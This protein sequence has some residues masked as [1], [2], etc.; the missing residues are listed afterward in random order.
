MTR[1]LL[2]KEDVL[3]NVTARDWQ[4]AVMKV[5]EVMEKQ[6]LIENRYIDSMVKVVREL[7]PYIVLAPGIAFPHAR[8]EDGALATGIGLIT[9][10]QPVP[11][12]NVDNDPVK[13]VIGLAAT[14]NT[15]HLGL[16]KQLCEF[17]EDDA[18]IDT[19]KNATDGAKVAELINQY[20][21]EEI[22]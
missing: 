13:I 3:L 6:G 17:L 20:G 2:R 12:G 7:G 10:S 11:F 1:P 9:L 18:N 19:L 5:G 22:K 15:S 8:P 21:K 16:L 14:D 4:N